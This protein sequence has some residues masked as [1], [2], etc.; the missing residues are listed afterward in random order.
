VV[1]VLAP[2]QPAHPDHLV[3]EECDQREMVRVIDVHELAQQLAAEPGHRPEQPLGQRAAGQPAAELEH[4][5]LVGRPHRPD[6]N[7]APVPQQPGLL[8]LGGVAGYHASRGYVLPSR[9]R[10]S[11]PV[12]LRGTHGTNSQ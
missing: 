8:Q 7:R 2:D 4:G 11:L 6:Q 9:R 10:R 5:L 3:V 1:G 12:A